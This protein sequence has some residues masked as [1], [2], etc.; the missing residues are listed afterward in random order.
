M[1]VGAAQ[2]T[3]G[4]SLQRPCH[5]QSGKRLLPLVGTRRAVEVFGRKWPKLLVPGWWG[6]DRAVA[7]LL[8]GAASTPSLCSQA[9]A[10]PQSQEREVWTKATTTDVGSGTH[11]HEGPGWGWRGVP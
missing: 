5:E 6:N 10:M 4:S 3:L 8:T 2:C 7:L 1:P 9:P 11:A